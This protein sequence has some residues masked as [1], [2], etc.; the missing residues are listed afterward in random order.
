MRFYKV[1]AQRAQVDSWAYQKA[2]LEYQE[3]VY[4]RESRRW[5]TWVPEGE[6][7][8]WVAKYNRNPEHK[9]SDIRPPQYKAV[10][11]GEGA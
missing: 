11:V 8:R 2:I 10:F 1:V 6:A 5:L 9:P 4:D 3:Q 7:R